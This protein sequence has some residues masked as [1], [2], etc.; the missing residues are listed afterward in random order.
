MGEREYTKGNE[1]YVE[2]KNV[3]IGDD[4]IAKFPYNDKPKKIGD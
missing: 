2:I 4:E 3:I 1:T